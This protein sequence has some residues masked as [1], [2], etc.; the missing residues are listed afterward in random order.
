MTY[1]WDDQRVLCSVPLDDIS[2]S[3]DWEDV[4][5]QLDYAK[6]NNSVAIIHAH[7]P[8]ETVTLGAIERLFTDAEERGLAPITFR[9]FDGP[10]RAALAF[11]FDDNSPELWLTA[12]DIFAAHNAHITLFV[13][14]WPTMT[15]EQH[16]DISMLAADG[17]DLE[18]HSISHPN[19]VKYV[20]ANG[21]DA[22]INNEVLPSF[23]PLEQLG[24]PA[25]TYAYPFG[26]HDDA[27][28][29]AVLAHVARV[30][31][32]GQCP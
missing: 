1:H 28:D 11:A 7:K 15:D 8:G 22:Y 2:K 23:A 18:P 29:K 19:A 17:H 30:R 14:R 13:A 26:A 21:L 6:D 4:D 12:Q 27:I 3:L 25:T 9:E 31:A 10:K 5:S 32:V 24:Y 20:D 16:A